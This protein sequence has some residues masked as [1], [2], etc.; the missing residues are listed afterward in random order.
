VLIAKMGTLE[1]KNGIV[2]ADE[3]MAHGVARGIKAAGGKMVESVE[4]TTPEKD[5]SWADII[6]SMHHMASKHEAPSKKPMWLWVHN[7]GCSSTIRL[8]EEATNT[9]QE[10][11]HAGKYLAKR[12]GFHYLPCGIEDPALFK[13]SN[14]PRKWSVSFVANMRL[15]R[16]AA[17]L[18]KRLQTTMRDVFVAGGEWGYAGISSVGPLPFNKVG[19][20][21]GESKVCLDHISEA[22]MEEGNSSTR[23]YQAI[24]CGSPVVSL[25]R[26][27]MVPEALRPHVHFANG[28]DE[29][30]NAILRLQS[31]SIERAKLR[32]DKANMRGH[33]CEDR[34]K[35]IWQ[36]VARRLNAW[37]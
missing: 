3:A 11:F 26:P 5:N 10:I 33:S 4:V 9:Y 36:H 31:H 25:Q 20:I 19:Q 14:H 28:Y 35:E 13:P 27:D 37:S 29:A 22:H 12:A 21:L 15:H 8:R 24:A 18:L 1:G 34:G 23:I 32:P 17:P 2:M 30:Y 6:I 16:E 7:P